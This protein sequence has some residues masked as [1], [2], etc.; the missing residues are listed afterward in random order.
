MIYLYLLLYALNLWKFNMIDGKFN[1]VFRGQTI[2]S[3][4]IV[5]VKQNMAKLFKSTP[6]A[7]E[8]LFTGQEVIIRKDLDYAAAMKYQ[9]A[10]KGAGALALIK[11]VESTESS[12]QE[13]TQS[14]SSSSAATFGANQASKQTES[15]PSNADSEASTSVTASTEAAQPEA[16]SDEALTVA[17]PG[18]QILPPKVYEKREVDT[19]ELSLAGVGERILPP[20]EPEKHTKP[21]IDHLSLEN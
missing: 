18:A 12:P 6:E 7:I 21:N 20:K 10:L 17:A 2:K 3:Q 5:S 15:N 13:P 16:K 19:S 4:D 14:Q 1:V 8:R 9:S 11:E